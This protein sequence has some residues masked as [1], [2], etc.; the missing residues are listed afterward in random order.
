MH[1]DDCRVQ[2]SY[3]GLR[4]ACVRYIIGEEGHHVCKQICIE[5]RISPE[6][7]TAKER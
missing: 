2:E 7:A 6:R 4:A 5:G 3:T 1:M